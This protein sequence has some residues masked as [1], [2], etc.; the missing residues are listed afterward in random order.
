MLIRYVLANIDQNVFVFFLLQ[1]LYHELPKHDFAMQKIRFVNAK[2]NYSIINNQYSALILNLIFKHS[3][4][5]LNR[6]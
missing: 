2:S 4:N 1:I 3:F 5:L 6:K